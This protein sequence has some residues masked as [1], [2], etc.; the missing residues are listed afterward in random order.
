MLTNRKEEMGSPL[1]VGALELDGIKSGSAPLSGVRTVPAPHE[2]KETQ[3]T[4]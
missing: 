3:R 1:A 4:K 2:I